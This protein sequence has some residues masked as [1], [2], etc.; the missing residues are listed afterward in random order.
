MDAITVAP[1]SHEAAKYAVMHWHYSR[2]MPV[3]KVVKFGAWENGRFL[4]CVLFDPGA[5][6][7]L[8]HRWGLTGFQ[9]CELRRVALDVHS[10]PVSQIVARCLR[11]LRE[12][13]AGLRLVVSF[14]DPAQ[15]H[16]GGIYQAGNWVYTG[17]TSPDVQFLVNGRWMHSRAVPHKKQ[18]GRAAQRDPAE[19][20]TLPTRPV[21]GKHRYLY[22]LDRAMRRQIAPFALPY[23]RGS[24]LDGELLASQAGG[25]G[26]TPVIRSMNGRSLRQ[27]ESHD[28]C[29]ED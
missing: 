19:L 2:R 15:N 11:M 20:R 21:S 23:P 9:V 8:G 16:H 6:D 29:A 13:N 1:C 5:S 7:A 18:M 24:G 28:F 22:P 25:T 10:T 4:G 12:T 27:G 14:A 26:S 3:S 17:T